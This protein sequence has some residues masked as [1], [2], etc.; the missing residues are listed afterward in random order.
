MNNVPPKIIPTGNTNGVGI[1]TVGFNTITKY[2]T[3]TLDVG[4]STANTFPF[5]VGDR[6]QIGQHSGDV[7]DIN[8]FKFTLMEVGH[9]GEGEQASGRIIHLSLIHI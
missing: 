1:S 4:F 8:F 2:A 9:W 6:I 5:V 7:I 3:I